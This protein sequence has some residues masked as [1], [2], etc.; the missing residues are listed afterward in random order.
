M[1]DMKVLGYRMTI[2]RDWPE[3][4]LQKVRELLLLQINK[5]AKDQALT[6]VGDVVITIEEQSATDEETGEWV[7]FTVMYG[8][9]LAR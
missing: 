3:F 7:E 6:I 8:E 9:A 5:Y 4:V 1:D 2:E